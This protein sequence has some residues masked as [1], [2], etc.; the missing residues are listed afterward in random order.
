[1]ANQ[2]VQLQP[3]VKK[4]IR[5]TFAEKATDTGDDMKEARNKD[6]LRQKEKELKE[7]QE[8]IDE[9]GKQIAEFLKN[10][11]AEMLAVG[12]SKAQNNLKEVLKDLGRKKRETNDIE[13]EAL[14]FEEQQNKQNE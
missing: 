7:M 4:M 1:M 6:N 3:I 10:R 2:M 8:E 14:A 9:E 12:E 5:K 13:E 11:K